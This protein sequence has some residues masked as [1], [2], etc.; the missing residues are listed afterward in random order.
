MLSF[1]NTPLPGSTLSFTAAITEGGNWLQ[2]VLIANTGED[3]LV[4]FTRLSQNF[5]ARASS[6][7]LGSGSGM[8]DIV[9]NGLTN[10]SYQFMAFLHTI[11][12]ELFLLLILLCLIVIYAVSMGQV[13]WAQLALGVLLILGPLFIPF[14]LV[15]PLAFL[16]WGWFKGMFTYTLYGAIAAALMRVFL[17]ASMGRIEA[18]MNGPPPGNSFWWHSTAWFLSIV[19]LV[20]AGLLSSLMIGTLASQIV[21]GGGAGGGIMGLVGQAAQGVSK[22]KT[23]GA[24]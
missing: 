14:L 22:L 18:I 20:T 6:M 9:L 16:F 11:I 15:E 7:E 17:A 23:G 12:F 3:Y 4:S 5:F 24:V 13:I 21:S 10:L 2:G 1:Y 19:P 8:L